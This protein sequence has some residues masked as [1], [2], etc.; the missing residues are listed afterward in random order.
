[1]KKLKLFILPLLC[2]FILTGCGRSGGTSTPTVNSY[3]VGMDSDVVSEMAVAEE[4]VPNTPE[5]K[6]INYV[7]EAGYDPETNSFAGKKIIYSANLNLETKDYEAAVASID[8]KI[9]QIEGIIIDSRD[10]NDY[11]NYWYSSSVRTGVR[12]RTLSI[13][14]RVPVEKFDEFITSLTVINGT[15]ITSKSIKSNDVT[16]TYN[17]NATRIESLQVQETRLLEILKEAQNV[18]EILEVEDRLEYVR[19]QLKTL[20]NTNS[21]LDYD[22]KMSPVTIYLKEVDRYTQDS[23]TYW[24]RVGESLSESWNNF[25]DFL[26]DASIWLIFALPFII[27]VI[28]VILLINFIRKKKGK[29]PLS[30]KRFFSSFKDVNLKSI[31]IIIAIL[32]G[33]CILLAIVNSLWW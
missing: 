27:L 22:I 29:E 28:L 16:Q 26:Q 10:E 18:S 14:V 17:D 33:V 9:S 23:Y 2:L 25:V 24:E 19:Y 3:S 31:L 1:M 13:T 4:D 6:E 20:T 11:D 30:V 21:A 32:I 5:P 12:G 15:H 8:E 7:D